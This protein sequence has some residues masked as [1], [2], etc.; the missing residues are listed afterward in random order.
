MQKDWPMHVRG[1]LRSEMTRRGITYDDLV[2]LLSAHGV[3]ETSPN[4]RNK[5]QRGLFSAVFFMQCL[6]AMGVQSIQVD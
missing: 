2:V 3:K 4:L 1:I 5:F 6:K